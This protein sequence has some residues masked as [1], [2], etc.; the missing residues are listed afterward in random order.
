MIFTTRFEVQVAF[1]TLISNELAEHQLAVIRE[2]VTNVGRHA[3][4]T[5]TSMTVRVSDGQC[6]VVVI[7]NG[8][9]IDAPADGS[10]GGSRDP[11]TAGREA[12]RAPGNADS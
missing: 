6:R 12:S 1:D 8:R 9:G 7:V 11:A 5:E 4:A 10:S 3:H 2:S